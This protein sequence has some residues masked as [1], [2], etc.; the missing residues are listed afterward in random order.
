MKDL[1][2]KST[3]PAKQPTL[4][5]LNP[6]WIFWAALA[7]LLLNVNYVFSGTGAAVIYPLILLYSATDVFYAGL[8]TVALLI[9]VVALVRVWLVQTARRKHR[10]WLI[11][12]AAQMTLV[13]SLLQPYV[14]FI[15]SIGGTYSHVARATLAGHV[16]QL[17]VVRGQ[18]FQGTSSIYQ[19]Y[20]CEPIG[21]FCIRGDYEFGAAKWATEGTHELVANPATNSLTIIANGREEFT[22]HP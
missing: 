22:L 17:G 8:I 18:L 6:L 20:K 3:P 4:D 21:L 1:V 2:P 7:I 15:S 12:F 9:G 16:Y 14:Y 19:L 5:R 11:G 10:A 13:S